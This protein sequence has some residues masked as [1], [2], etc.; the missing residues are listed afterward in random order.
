MGNCIACL[1]RQISAPLR[2]QWRYRRWWHGVM[3]L[4]I[5]LTTSC[6]LS[7]W[8]WCHGCCISVFKSLYLSKMDPWE[9][10]VNIVLISPLLV[11]CVQRL[12]IFKQWPPSHQEVTE[13]LGG[14]TTYV[15]IA[16]TKS[17]PV[18]V[19]YTKNRWLSSFVWATRCIWTQRAAHYSKQFNKCHT[20]NHSKSIP[21]MLKCA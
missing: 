11:F 9:K 21:P 4:I 7:G 6:F 20:T 14:I 3:I 19:E 2:Q 17:G 15:N 8:S 12:I 10:R 16:I 13:Y 18:A 1:Y 5:N